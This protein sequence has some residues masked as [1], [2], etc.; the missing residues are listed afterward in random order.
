MKF[1]D[2]F[3]RIYV[4]NLPYRKDRREAT[5]RELAKVGMPFTLE[6][7]ELFKAIRADSAGSF[8]SLGARGCFLSHLMILKQAKKQKLN[9][10]LILED[11][12]AF[13]ENFKT[14]EEILTEQ[15]SQTDWDLVQFGYMPEQIVNPG[16]DIFGTFREFSGSIIGAHFVGIN[17]NTI[18]RLIYFLEQLM[19]RP[20]G[21]PEGGPMPIDGAFNVFRQQNPDVVRLISVPTFGYQRSSRSDVTPSWVDKIF[22]LRLIAEPARK[23]GFVKVLKIFLKSLSFSTQKTNK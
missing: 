11:D 23:L 8:P 13:A 16:K 14:S 22:I 1:I 2:F 7:V 18:P 20:L 12:I 10:I 9:N 17:G 3:D 15:L 6:K 5:S 21:H 4:L 19:Q